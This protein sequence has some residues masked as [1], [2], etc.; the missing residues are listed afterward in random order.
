MSETK[1]YGTV[2]GVPVTDDTL[3]EWEAEIDTQF[4]P[5]DQPRTRRGRPPLGR[6]GESGVLQVRL[7]SELEQTLQRQAETSGQ[8]RS[9]I[10][11][12]A[13]REHLMP[14]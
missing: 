14:A 4:P 12:A 13:L 7:A 11:R 6:S 5:A 3:A 1:T 8:T 10:M 9:Q 2:N